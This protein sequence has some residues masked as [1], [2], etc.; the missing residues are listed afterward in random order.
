MGS[1]DASLCQ[2]G[3]RR[4]L[5]PTGNTYCM[6]GYYEYTSAEMHFKKKESNTKAK[7]WRDTPLL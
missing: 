4:L 2:R 6:L 7:G 5:L 1:T 3:Q